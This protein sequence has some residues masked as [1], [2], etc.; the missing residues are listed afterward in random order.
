MRHYNMRIPLVFWLWGRRRWRMWETFTALHPVCSCLQC[1]RASAGRDQTFTKNNKHKSRRARNRSC[2]E[3]KSEK[4]NECQ[5]CLKFCEL[6]FI[7]LW[8]GIC[9]CGVKQVY[10]RQWSGEAG[11]LCHTVRVRACRSEPGRSARPA[12]PAQ[13]VTAEYTWPG[14][15]RP[16]R[17]N[18]ERLP[19]QPQPKLTEG[20]VCD[21][22]SKQSEV[23]SVNVWLCYHAEVFCVYIRSIRLCLCLCV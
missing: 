12:P 23:D 21:R 22:R 10:T 8:P 18:W 20:I 7:L 5:R 15:F 2:G 9:C 4:K 6:T 11:S 16:S 19:P 14:S 3:L 1:V 17:D 13:G